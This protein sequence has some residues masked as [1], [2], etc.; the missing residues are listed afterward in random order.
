MS[1][2]V[3]RDVRKSYNR[4][5]D[6]LNDI[7]L[8][9]RDKEF[10]VIVGPS[11][12]GKTTTLRI[13]AGLE[14]AQRGKILIDGQ[15]VNDLSARDRDIALVFQNYALYPH[16]TVRENMG[17]GLKVRKTS[18]DVIA[19]KVSEAA[20]LLGISPLLDRKPNQLSGGECQRVAMGRAI[21][22]SPKAFLFDEPLSNLDAQLRIQM[23][24]ELKKL[25][26]GIGTTSLLVT[27]DQ[28]EAMTL[29]DTIF[30]MKQGRIVQ[31]GTPQE[32]YDRPT[33]TFVASFIGSPSMNLFKGRATRNGSGLSLEFLGKKLALDPLGSPVSEN[34][35]V[36]V[37]VRPEHVTYPN[38]G[39]IPIETIVQVTEPI[40]SD[41]FV[42]LDVNGT[43]I[44]GRLPSSAVETNSRLT[45]GINKDKIHLFALETGKSLGAIQVNARR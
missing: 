3:L 42:V 6:V 20:E 31:T 34:E 5:H 43:E 23:R 7:N 15:V 29:A 11:G 13:I 1:E 16:M 41:L 10:A 44:M 32:I 14:Q 33:D 8:T 37:G 28:M 9:V 18:R 25:H 35:D 27:H 21:V 17:F 45:V 12:C 39:L 4:S 2:I 19:R 30:V 40:G 26:R 38:D 36:L 24:G 22:R